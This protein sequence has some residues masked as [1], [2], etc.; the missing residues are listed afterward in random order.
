MCKVVQFR[1]LCLYKFEVGD[2]ATQ[3]TKNIYCVKGEG[4]VDWSLY[5]NKMV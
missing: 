3:A 5:S 2:N 4:T 1:N